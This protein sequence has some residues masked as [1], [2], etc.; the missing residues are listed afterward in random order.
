[1]PDKAK[2]VNKRAKVINDRRSRSA[3]EMDRKKNAKKTFKNPTE[4]QFRL[5][6]RSPN[7]YDIDGVDGKTRR[8]KAEKPNAAKKKKLTKEEEY[9]HYMSLSEEYVNGNIS[10]DEDMRARLEDD[11]HGEIARNSRW[12]WNDRDTVKEYRTK[13]RQEQAFY[14]NKKPKKNRHKSKK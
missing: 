11:D 10:Y 9:A 6:A 8:T 4:K 3:V 12:K 1:M 13:M 7:R 14:A 2:D 5:W